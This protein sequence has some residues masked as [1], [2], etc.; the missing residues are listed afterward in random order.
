MALSHYGSS[1]HAANFYST[2]YY[3]P[4]EAEEFSGANNTVN[5]FVRLKLPMNVEIELSER[6][7]VDERDMLDILT[8][9]AATGVFDE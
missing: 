4:E 3:A 5:P 8:L 7:R 2:R 9:V 1:Y 6:I